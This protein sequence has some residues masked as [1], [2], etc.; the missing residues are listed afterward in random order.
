MATHGDHP[1]LPSHLE[2]LLMDDVHTV[3]LKADCP[4]R[5]KRGAI[6]ALKLVEV[7]EDDTVWAVSYTHL[8]LPTKA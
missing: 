4:S 7:D 5:V 6:G 8:T 2:S 3:F 1:T